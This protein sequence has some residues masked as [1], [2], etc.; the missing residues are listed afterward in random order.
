MH[1]GRSTHQPMRQRPTFFNAH[2]LTLAP[3]NC[4]LAVLLDDLTGVPLTILMY[5]GSARLLRRVEALEPLS[6]IGDY[7]ASPAMNGERPPSSN[8]QRVCRWASQVA[9]WLLCAVLARVLETAVLLV[10]LLE[11]LM[12]AANSIG[13]WACSELEVEA[14]QWLHL[15]VVP[16]CL[17]AAQFTI[18]NLV[19]DGRKQRG[20][21]DPDGSAGSGS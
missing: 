15:L 1:L 13:W 12:I 14:K 19:L 8:A 4:T 20:S 17:D 2:R 7:E 11:Q 21:I 18:Q 5:I 9:H 3:A 6:R 16:L 10:P